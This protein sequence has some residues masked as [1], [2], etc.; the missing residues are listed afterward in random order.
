MINKYNNTL[1]INRDWN[2]M[3]LHMRI[4]SGYTMRD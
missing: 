3:D 1:H 2:H 4:L